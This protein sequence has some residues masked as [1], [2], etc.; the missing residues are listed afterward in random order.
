MT[1]GLIN[2]NPVVQAKKEGLVRRE[3]QYRDDGVDP[4]E[5]TKYVRDIRDPEH[6]YTLEQ[7]RVVSEESVT[8]DDKLDRIL[9][10]FTPTI[11]HCS[12]ANIIGL[13]LRAKLKECLQLHYKVDIRVSPGSHADEVSVNKQLN[14]KERVV[15]ALENPNLRQLV[16]E[17]IYSD[18]I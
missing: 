6:P 12:M 13:C 16:D 8:V 17:C 10:T 11:Q 9:I 7:L 2:A 4:L 1:L 15:A 14:D 3:D 5:M 18:E